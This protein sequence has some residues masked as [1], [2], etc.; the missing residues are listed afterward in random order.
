MAIH[1]EG[2]KILPR[3]PEK[4]HARFAKGKQQIFTDYPKIPPLD[5][6]AQWLP[7]AHDHCP[8]RSRIPQINGPL[9]RASLLQRPH[10]GHVYHFLVSAVSA[11]LHAGI[12]HI[13]IFSLK[14]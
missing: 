9:Q 11:G 5:T 14:S 12:L 13:F 10:E 7:C 2:N 8:S 1:V 4:I 6:V 3:K